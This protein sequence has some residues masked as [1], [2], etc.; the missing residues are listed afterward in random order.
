[1]AMGIDQSGAGIV[2]L[3]NLTDDFDGLFGVQ[4]QN[5][6]K[7]RKEFLLRTSNKNKTKIRFYSAA[8]ITVGVVGGEINSRMN[9]LQIPQGEETKENKEKKTKRR[10]SGERDQTIP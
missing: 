7:Q 10:E 3:K 2:G 6:L 1:M 4:T 9:W 8:V 5:K